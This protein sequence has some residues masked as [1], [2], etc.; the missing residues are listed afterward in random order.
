MLQYHSGNPHTLLA[1]LW[2]IQQL[3]VGIIYIFASLDS[4]KWLNIVLS[5]IQTHSEIH[6]HL[7]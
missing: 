7:I 1:L 2:I 4:H 6:R 3:S 5:K